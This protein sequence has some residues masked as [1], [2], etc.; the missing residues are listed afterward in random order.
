VTEEQEGIAEKRLIKP[1]SRWSAE[2]SQVDNLAK[3]LPRM[4]GALNK[5]FKTKLI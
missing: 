2:T 5:D 3:N 1:F 4:T